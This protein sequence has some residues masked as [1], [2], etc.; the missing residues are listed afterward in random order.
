LFPE[1]KIR[2]VNGMAVITEGGNVHCTTQQMPA[3][4]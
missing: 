1:R 2:T 4:Q 3:Q